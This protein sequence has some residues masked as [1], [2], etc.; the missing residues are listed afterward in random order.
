MSRTKSII[1][2]FTR[3]EQ[4]K[5]NQRLAIRDEIGK[6]NKIEQQK[7][8][9]S[10]LSDIYESELEVVDRSV[11]LELGKPRDVIS[12]HLSTS[13]LLQHD[14]V[15]GSINDTENDAFYPANET[16]HQRTNLRRHS[17]SSESTID[18]ATTFSEVKGDLRR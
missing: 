4:S 17:D 15:G 2:P 18:E 5:I 7:L 16:V 11:V 6:S 8:D 13:N 12:H 9:N 14:R 1:K 3:A 10:A